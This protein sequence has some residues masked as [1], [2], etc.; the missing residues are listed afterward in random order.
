MNTR[1]VHISD[2]HGFH[3][4]LTSKAFPEFHI[5]KCDILIHSG[6]F[7]GRGRKGETEDFLKW[8]SGLKQAKHKVLI[9]GNHDLCLDPKFNFETGAYSWLPE[10]KERYFNLGNITYLEDS[11]V[12]LKGLK[13]WGSPWTPWFH[14]DNWAFNKHRGLEIKEIWDKIPKDI[15]IIVTHGPLFGYL[16]KVMRGTY[17]GCEDLFRAVIN[18]DC[19]LHLCGHIHEGYG[20]ELVKFQV[21]TSNASICDFS[22]DPINKPKLF[23][24][25]K[26]GDVIVYE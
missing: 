13:I 24:I 23:E 17:E 16:D 12:T 25:T 20:I 14:G 21:V 19:R 1:I 26:E 15:N 11:S 7:S 5:P 2:S 6:D 10:L 8:F 3:L 22:Y 9:A 18:T 4:K